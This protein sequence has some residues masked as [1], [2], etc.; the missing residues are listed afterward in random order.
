MKRL[1]ILFVLFAI[2]SVFAV[3]RPTRAP[4]MEMAIPWVFSN[5]CENTPWCGGWSKPTC[6]DGGGHVYN[7]N[8]MKYTYTSDKAFYYEVEA[9]SRDYPKASSPFIK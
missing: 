1:F 4:D 2:G 9:T 3:E 5:Y 8:G 7:N 6:V